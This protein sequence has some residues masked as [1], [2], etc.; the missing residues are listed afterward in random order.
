MKQ[1]LSSLRNPM[2]ITYRR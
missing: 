1:N 2:L